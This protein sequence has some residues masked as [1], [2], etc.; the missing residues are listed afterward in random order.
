M[1]KTGQLSERVFLGNE[2]CRERGD[3]RRAKGVDT[4]GGRAQMESREG[5]K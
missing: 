4:N 3:V 5:G 2:R 1:R